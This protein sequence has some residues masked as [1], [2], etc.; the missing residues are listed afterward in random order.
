MKLMSRI[1]LTGLVIGGASLLLLGCMQRKLLFFPSHEPSGAMAGRGHLAEWVVEG[2]LYGFAREVPASKRVWLVMHGNAGQAAQRGYMLPCFPAGDSVYI[3]EYP[4]Y[5]AREGRPSRPSFNEAAE[6]AYRELHRRYPGVQLCVFGESIGTGPT[7]HLAALTPAPS[8][9]VLVVPFD[10]L[11][12]VAKE[13]LPW[14]PV[15]ILMMD[16]WDNTE[17]LAA[18]GGRVDIYAAT[19]DQVIPI[20]H[21]RKLAASKEGAHFHELPCGHNEWAQSGRVRI[22]E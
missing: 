5:G 2:R 10:R 4:G 11:V 7:C 1:V 18:Y 12:E 8:R 17:A 14:F 19:Y 9:V 13:K 22:G 16:R 6:A 20:A 15:G 3:L 21:A